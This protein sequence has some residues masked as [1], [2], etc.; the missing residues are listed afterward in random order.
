[1]TVCGWPRQTCSE[2]AIAMEGNAPSIA[3]P[4]RP[5]GLN[6]AEAAQRDR[7]IESRAWVIGAAPSGRELGCRWRI[8]LAQRRFGDVRC[9]RGERGVRFLRK[10]LFDAAHRIR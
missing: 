3:T 2:K 10:Q 7:A 4:L 5:S 8:V 1:M 6:Q 9:R